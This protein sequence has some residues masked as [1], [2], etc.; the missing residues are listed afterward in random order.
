MQH[1]CQPICGPLGDAR[2]SESLGLRSSGQLVNIIY[3]H[4][5]EGV[6]QCHGGKVIGYDDAHG[7]NE[8]DVPGCRSVIVLQSPCNEQPHL[9]VVIIQS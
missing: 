2:Y 7:I 8:I 1:I 5:L 4:R 9:V 3:S 6:A